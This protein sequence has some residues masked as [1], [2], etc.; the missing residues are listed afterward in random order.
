MA[1]NLL[2]SPT[3][4]W[5]RLRYQVLGCILVAG[6]VPYLARRFLGPP[7]LTDQLHI[8]LLASILAMTLGAWLA[9]EVSTYPGVEAS[10]YILPSFSVAYGF[11]VLILLL[12]RIDYARFILVSGFVLGVIWFFF[13]QIRFQSRR[14]LRLGVIPLGAVSSL[15]ALQG[16]EWREMLDPLED[17]SGLQAV[18]VDLHHDLPDAWER[19]LADFALAGLPVYHCKQLVESMTGRVELEHMSENSFGT[20]S[21]A[22]TYMALKHTTDWLMAA[23]TLL[24]AILPLLVIA[25]AIRLDSS[26]PALFRQVRIGYRGRPFRVFKFR[27]MT[28]RPAAETSRDAA[29]TMADDL[30]ITRVGRLLRRSRLDEV[31]QL[32]NV[33]RGEMSWIGP[34][35]EAQVLSQ[36]YEAEIPFYRY[37][38]IVR[39]GITGWAQINQGHVA[40]VD[41]V[42]AK[43]QYDFFYIKNFSP[44]LDLLIVARTVR[45]MLTGYGA[46]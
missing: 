33:L 13:L 16:V 37:R 7:A 5:L 45:T 9:R 23:L 27:T 28:D 3:R 36:W 24:A 29:M 14:R 43:L 44:W 11:T 8:T 30:R 35:P 21:P 26:G 18:V 42:I 17:F 40:R 31:P 32:L 39:P 6:I 46:R 19:R 10:A 22:S 15:K 34:R 4:G 41:E 20:L 25:F 1:L 12:G 2:R 38:H